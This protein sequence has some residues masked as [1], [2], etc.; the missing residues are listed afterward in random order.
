MTTMATTP[1]Q[2]QFILQYPNQDPNPNP[3]PNPRIQAKYS[4]KPWPVSRNLL[5]LTNKNHRA[6]L[7]KNLT[8]STVPIN[9]NSEDSCFIW[10]W[11][12]KPRKSHSS[13]T[14][15]KLPTLCHS[16]RERLSI[17]LSL[18]W[19]ITPTPPEPG[20]TPKLEAPQIALINAATFMHACKLEGSVTFRL[21]LASLELYSCAASIPKTYDLVDLL[22]IPE[23][24]HDFA[25]VFSKAKADTL[26][27]HRP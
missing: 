7:S 4:P 19:W 9:E 21:D 18:T 17:T 2:A 12:S 24:Y 14:L 5:I 26:A 1:T 20:S 16:W 13:L 15:T 23:D 3:N 25:D 6:S 22:D 8:S 11:T 10:I 27:P